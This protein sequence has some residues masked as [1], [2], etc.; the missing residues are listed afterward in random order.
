MDS[1]ETIP[2]LLLACLR[3]LP[4][5]DLAERLA[6]CSVAEWEELV[7]LSTEQQVAALFYHRLKAHGCEAT[8]PIAIQ[9][10]LKKLYQGNVV[11][12]MRRYHALGQLVH[13]LHNQQIPVLI[14]KGA[15]L[16]AT[17]YESIA[18][19]AMV[20]IDILIPEANIA[21]AVEQFTA[22]GYRPKTPWLS[23]EAYLTNR[24]HI[25]P[26][27]HP[28]AFVSVELHWRI[29]PPNRG[30]AIPVAELWSRAKPATVNGVITE[31]LSAEDLLLHICVHATYHHWFQHGVRSLCDIA[32]LLRHYATD[33]NWDMIT[34][35][36]IAWELQPG[37][38]LALSAAQQLLG[39]NIPTEVLARLN[40]NQHPPF[41]TDE[42][43]VL[44]FPEHRSLIESPTSHFW[45]FLKKSNLAAKAQML[46]ERIFISPEEMATKYAIAIDS[47]WRYFYYGVRLRDLLGRFGHRVWRMHR[48]DPTMTAIDKQHVRLQHWLEKPQHR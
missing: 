2:D 43:Y 33:L 25:P 18:L 11:R 15:N 30:Y 45:K 26:F 22:L 38:F 34:A 4:P 32:E 37:V 46:V 47:P 42:L 16:A 5:N 1:I 24:H 28:D 13:A 48:G 19:R 7:V 40:P 27:I 41:S 31:G 39:V 17:V 44:L 10:Q 3:H 21:A 35:R 23:L 6:Q 14:L 36:A 8:M 12:N 29:T 9:K 20:D